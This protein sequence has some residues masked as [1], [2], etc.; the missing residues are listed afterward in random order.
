ME[1]LRSGVTV[2][3]AQN[4]V[5]V[6]A[7]RLQ[8]EYP[9]EKGVTVRVMPE[10]MARPIPMR[11]LSERP[12]IFRPM[13]TLV[14]TTMRRRRLSEPAGIEVLAAGPSRYPRLQD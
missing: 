14:V 6:I 12:A 10:P 2:G 11:F 3:T 7:Q 1:R 8:H 5:D 4:A 9:Q 13:S